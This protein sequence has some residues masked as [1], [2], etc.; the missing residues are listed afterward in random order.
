MVMGFEQDGW[1]QAQPR[2]R[3]SRTGAGQPE[4]RGDWQGFHARLAAAHACRT[5]L[6][7]LVGAQPAALWQRS[8]GSFDPAT[9][10]SLLSYGCDQ[11]GVN[12]DGLANGKALGR[13]LEDVVDAPTRGDRG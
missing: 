2:G 3:D 8:E 7:D 11:P 1:P 10:R 9:A 6:A 5:A 13:N 12:R 4:S